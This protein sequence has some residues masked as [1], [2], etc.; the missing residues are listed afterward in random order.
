LADLTD[1]DLRVPEASVETAWR[2]ATTLTG[3]AVIGVHV[4]EALPPGALD[5]VE[6]AFRSSASLAAG[7]ERLAPYGRCSKPRVRAHTTGRQSRDLCLH[8]CLRQH[9]DAFS[10]N[11]AILF[12]EELANERR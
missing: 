8:E 10:K 2:L 3:D 4:A 5:L 6:Y 11:V 12:L 1:P 9:A 7:L